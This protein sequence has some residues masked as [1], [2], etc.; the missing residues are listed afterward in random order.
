MMS[1]TN[2]CEKS[3]LDNICYSKHQTS[4]KCEQQFIL[5]GPAADSE[6]KEVI[7]CDEKVYYFQQ[8]KQ[9]LQSHVALENKKNKALLIG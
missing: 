4:Y 7:I 3:F 1:E 2:L 5:E 6:V 8:G 9:L